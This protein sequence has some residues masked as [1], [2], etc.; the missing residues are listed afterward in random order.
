M[1]SLQSQI[2]QLQKELAQ[3]N[4]EFNPEPVTLEA[5]RTLL[6]P[7]AALVE[8]FQYRPYDPQAE[9]GERYGD[10]RYAAYILT[11]QGDPVGIDLGEVKPIDTRLGFFRQQLIDPGSTGRLRQISQLVYQAVFQPLEP[12]LGEAQHLLISPDGNLNLI[13]FAALSNQQ[14]QYLLENYQLTTL[15]SGRDLVTYQQ[16]YAAAQPPVIVTGKQIGRA[17]V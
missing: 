2:D 5:I 16:D 17:H 1:Q 10:P 4:P 6:P 3:N 7:D 12:Y 8:F 15:S 14:G 9:Q 11:P 13:P